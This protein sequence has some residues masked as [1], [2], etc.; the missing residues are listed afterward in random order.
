MGTDCLVT[1]GGD[2]EN[3]KLV[4]G[5]D[6]NNMFG[7]CRRH[8]CMKRRRQRCE[9]LELLSGRWPASKLYESVAVWVGGAHSPKTAASG[10]ALIVVVQGV[11]N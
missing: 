4:A 9:Y 8:D 3:A 1:T 7:S 10:A 6:A 2:A 5:G 11:R